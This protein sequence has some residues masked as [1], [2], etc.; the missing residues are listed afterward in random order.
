MNNCHICNVLLDTSDAD[1]ERRDCGGDCLRCMAE[2]G[3][4]DCALHW[5]QMLVKRLERINDI[6]FADSI[7]L[8]SNQYF[9]IRQLATEHFRKS[10]ERVG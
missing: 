7:I 9:E 5:A 8:G 1:N 10:V 6:V 2:S 3:D 4:P